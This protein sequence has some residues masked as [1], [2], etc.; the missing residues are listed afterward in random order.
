MQERNF[1]KE[2]GN[3]DAEPRR[4][5]LARDIVEAI[6]AE[7]K[8]DPGMDIMDFGCGTGLVGMLLRPQVRSLTCV[9]NSQ[10]MLDV[11]KS[12]VAQTGIHGVTTRLVDV[13]K[14][15]ELTGSYD[16]IVSAMALH[17]IEDV[18]ELARQFYKVLR[19]SGFV[20]IADLETEQGKFHEDHSGVFHHGFERAQLSG[21][22]AEAGFAD[23]RFRRAAE[24]EKPSGK[25][26]VF[27]M[28]GSKK[29]RRI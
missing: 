11:L 3:W 14:G 27:L 25:F 4:V 23:I 9:D 18:A 16:C 24:V 15:G 2:A 21:I 7:I 19:T 26:P 1:D 13:S 22:F 20:C 17:H 12:K 29:D 8:L 5:K 6:K 28:V 10:G